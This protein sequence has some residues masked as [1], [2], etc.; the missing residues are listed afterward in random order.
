MSH[1]WPGHPDLVWRKAYRCDGGTCV[2]VAE[3]N[4]AILISDSKVPDGPVLS[5]TP[6]EFREFIAGA[7]NGDFDDL[8]E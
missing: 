3:S 6:I 8:I 5:Y 2:Q 7:K 1:G 4:G